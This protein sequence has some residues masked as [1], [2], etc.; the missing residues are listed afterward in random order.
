MIKENRGL[1][2]YKDI[3]VT[4][5]AG[6][7]GS[8]TCVTTLLERGYNVVIVDNFSNAPPLVPSRIKEIVGA[9]LAKNLTTYNVDIL[10]TSSLSKVFRENPDIS[11]VIHF[12]GV[13]AV[14]ESIS[15][16]AEYYHNNIEGTVPFILSSDFCHRLV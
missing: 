14:G 6:F 9:D 5:G 12:A 2:M 3:L 16:P 4:G 7:I 15:K 10:D 11:A 8:H 13:K 1:N